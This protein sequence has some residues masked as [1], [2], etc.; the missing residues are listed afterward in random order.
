MSIHDSFATV[1]ERMA[2]ATPDAPAVV[3]G[4]RRLRWADA[5]DRAARLATALEAAG[6]GAGSHIALYQYN[7]PE[8]MECLFACSKLRAVSTMA[9]IAAGT[10]MT[11]N[12]FKAA[13]E[14]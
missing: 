4:N 8:Y 10:S 5:D 11:V 1:W 13:P 12:A 3:Q 7:A 2:D 6:A 14:R 9:L